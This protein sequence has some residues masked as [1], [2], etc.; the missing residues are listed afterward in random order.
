[1]ANARLCFGLLD[2]YRVYGF[3]DA[4]GLARSGRLLLAASN[5]H[6]MRKRRAVRL[7]STMRPKLARLLSLRTFFQRDGN[8][9]THTHLAAMFRGARSMRAGSLL[10]IVTATRYHHVLISI[11][12]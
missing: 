5:R 1:M 10:G 4:Y 11:D 7:G 9:M 2:L 6:R 8:L 3:Y 12:F